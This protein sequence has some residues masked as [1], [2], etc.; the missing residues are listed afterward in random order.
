MASNHKI[1]SIVGARP[2]FVKAAMLSNAWK[3]VSDFEEI[4]VHTGQHYDEVM[5][6]VFFQQMGIPKPKYNLQVGSLSHGAQTGRMI[7][8]LERVMMEEKPKWVVVYGDTNSTLAGALSAVKLHIPVA[9]VE[10]GLRSFNRKMPEEINRI[11][12]DQLSTIL[13]TP[14]SL[15]TKCLIDEGY[16]RG[17]IHE[18]GDVMF[19]A[20]RYFE[21]K[22]QV[23]EVG[24]NEKEFAL[25]TIHRA[26]NTDDPDIMGSIVAGL[27]ELSK[28]MDIVWPIHP[29]T[30]NALSKYGLNDKM[31]R[32]PVSYLE[33]LE[34][35]RKARVVVTDSGGVQKESFFCG[36][37]CVTCRAETEW[38]ELVECGW[39][40]LADPAKQESIPDAVVQALYQFDQGLPVPLLYGDGNAAEKMTK[41]L[42]QST[43]SSL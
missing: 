38:V 33:M 40:R 3:K 14:T 34:L 41:V 17:S 30:K 24:T 20:C 32:S 1:L 28:K 13:F 29:R 9:H 25:V 35:M 16:E 18:V 10:A 43:P 23:D 15:A 12:V 37:P 21:R 2:Q 7:E 26:E 6:E 22:S 5:S 11:V 8:Q 42:I 4:I 27:E 39:N 31:G 36:T 19:D